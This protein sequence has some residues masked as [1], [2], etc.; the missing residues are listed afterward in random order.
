MSNNPGEVFSRDSYSMLLLLRKNNDDDGIGGLEVIER[1]A[2]WQKE[3]LI[4]GAEGIAEEIVEDAMSHV[5]TTATHKSNP[6]PQCSI[7]KSK[8]LW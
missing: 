4:N 2:Q 7:Y 8:S 3:G 1:E 6:L 5:T